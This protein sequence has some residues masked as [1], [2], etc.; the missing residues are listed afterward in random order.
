MGRGTT[1][2]HFLF[3]EINEVLKLNKRILIKEV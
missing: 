3:E 1:A 2:Q